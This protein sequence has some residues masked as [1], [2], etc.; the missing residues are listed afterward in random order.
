M[1]IA[2]QGKVFSLFMSC[3]YLA[4]GAVKSHPSSGTTEVH[5]AVGFLP[6]SGNNH[7]CAELLT[8]AKN[9]DISLDILRA[10]G[11]SS[12]QSSTPIGGQRSSPII[13]GDYRA[14]SPGT[15]EAQRGVASSAR[16]SL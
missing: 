7:Q 4:V 6:G 14:R 13:G 12:L 3:G 5:D 2:N 8:V 11:S 15:L 1:L 16:A 9:T 10:C